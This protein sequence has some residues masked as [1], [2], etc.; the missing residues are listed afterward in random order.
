MGVAGP[1]W[2]V[3]TDDELRSIVVVSPHFD[4]AVMG[5]GQVL[6]AHPHSTVITVFGGPPERYP[7][8]PTDWDARGGFVAGDD[9][10]AMRREEDRAA[11]AVLKA[12]HGWL[13]FVDHQYLE[14]HERSSTEKVAATLDDA[15]ASMNPTAVFLPMGLANPD[16]DSTHEAGLLVRARRSDLAWF[17]Y[18][19]AGYKHLPGLLAWRITKLFKSGLWPTPAAVP[20]NTDVTAKNRAISCYRSQLRPLNEDHDLAARLRAN[21]SE[22]YWRLAE[23]PE[24][25]EGLTDLA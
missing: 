2:G 4:D 17:C 1:T 19:D 16:H 8:P 21:V 18:E 11:L 15:M 22:Q 12:D 20:V 5:A 7:D 9:V 10:V 14:A 25:W 6:E 13:G 3:V 24:G 23:P